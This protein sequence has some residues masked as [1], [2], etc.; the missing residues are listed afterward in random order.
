MSTQPP[1]PD[2]Q[3]RPGD[4]VVEPPMV[5]TNATLKR[6]DEQFPGSE[7]LGMPDDYDG[8]DDGFP[9]QK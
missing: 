8:H 3:V 5:L 6:L 2:E 1:N 9:D 7:D 4:D